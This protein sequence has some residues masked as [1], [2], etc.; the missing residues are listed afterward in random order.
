MTPPKKTRKV[1]KTSNKKRKVYTIKDQIKYIKNI[2][3]KKIVGIY[4]NTYRQN[5]VFKDKKGYFYMEDDPDSG[6]DISH[7]TYIK[8]K[9]VKKKR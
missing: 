2:K 6:A 8:K 3:K 4:Q 9:D 7:K 5:N 1:R